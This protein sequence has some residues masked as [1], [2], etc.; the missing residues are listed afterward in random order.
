MTLESCLIR[1]VEKLSSAKGDAINPL[2]CERWSGDFVEV[3]QNGRS[4]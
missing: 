3:H 4:M 1:Q 2:K